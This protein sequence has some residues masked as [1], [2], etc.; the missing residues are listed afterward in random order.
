[1]TPRQATIAD[2]TVLIN[3]C[4]ERLNDHRIDRDDREHMRRW[5]VELKAQRQ[6][7]LELELEE[8]ND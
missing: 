2:L 4:T 5:L 3:N 1:M 7:L 8:T 6:E